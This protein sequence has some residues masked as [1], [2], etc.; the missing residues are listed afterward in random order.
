MAVSPNRIALTFGSGN[1]I[2]FTSS[3]D[4][5]RNFSEPIKVV[6]PGELSLGMHRGPRIAFAGEAIVISAIAGAQGKGKDGDLLAWRSTDGGK[7]W[8]ASMTINDVPGS[9]REG[10]HAMASDGKDLLFT[11]WL[12]LRSKGTKLYGASSTDGGKHW[13]KNVLVYESPDGTICQCCHP[14]ALVRA[15]GEIDVMWRNALGGSRDLYLASSRDGGKR[16]EAQK[17]GRDTWKLSACPMDG[18]GLAIG[19]GGRIVSAWRRADTVYTD[20]AGSPEIEI[21]KGK[22]PSIAHAPN[23]DYIMWVTSTGLMVKAP[24]DRDAVLLDTHGKSG[25]LAGTGPVFAAWESNQSIKVSRIDGLDASAVLER[26]VSR[27]RDGIVLT[28]SVGDLGSRHAR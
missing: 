2:Y 6:E 28:Q 12:D 17:L 13:S 27:Q 5:G 9:A 24:K 15:D 7:S 4:G 20:V 11:T 23:G 26:P 21:A 22:D 8:S 16:F 10:L 19:E 25:V 3:R 14:S 1:A 18:G